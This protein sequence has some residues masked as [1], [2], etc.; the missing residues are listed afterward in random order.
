M[1]FKLKKK[2]LFPQKMAVIHILE[3]SFIIYAYTINLFTFYGF[4]VFLCILQIY[5]FFSH[6]LWS[7]K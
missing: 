7:Y 5:H 4:L 2:I 6:F 1:H 3:V